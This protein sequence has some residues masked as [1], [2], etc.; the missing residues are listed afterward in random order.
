MRTKTER[1]IKVAIT[2]TNGIPPR[3]GGFETL[4]EYLT[5]Y[6]SNKCEITVYCSN[7]QYPRIAERNN[8]KLVYLPLKANGWQSILYDSL[9]I[10]MTSRKYDKVI[11]LGC[12]S[13]LTIRLF[14]RFGNKFILNEGGIDW[15]REKWGPIASLYMRIA[16][17]TVVPRCKTIVADNE[18]IQEYYKNTYGRE[19]VLIEY[20]GDQVQKYHVSD[21]YLK[22]YKFLNEIYYLNVARIQPDNNIEMIING[23]LLCENKGKLVI[24]GNWSFSKYGK[25]LKAKYQSN[26]KLILLDAIYD[27]KALNVIRSNAYLYIHGHSAGGTNPALV[28]AMN[29]SLPIICFNS[30][31][32]RYTTE[33]KS[34]YFDSSIELKELLTNLSSGIVNN[35]S[36]ELNKIAV[37]R[38]KWE[39]IANKYFELIKS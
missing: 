9:S 17:R 5:K 30:I 8:C 22:E 10:I 16:E 24:I 23:F 37:R 4:V 34:L 14:S 19:S 35:I 13:I 1:K 36:D 6:L 3:Y 7:S 31:Y 18:G 12:A 29:L 21:K 38:Y 39:I 32:N 26:E 27:Q 28:E 25:N 15:K 20:G 33:N 2:G 11:V